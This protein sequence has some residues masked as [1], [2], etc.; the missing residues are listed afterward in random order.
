MARNTNT[1]ARAVA[2][3]V[4]ANTV[5][6]VKAPKAAPVIPQM[7]K[8]DDFPAGT[9]NTAVAAVVGPIADQLAEGVQGKFPF[10]DEDTAEKLGLQI[11]SALAQRHGLRLRK[12]YKD[13][14]LFVKA[15]GPI[16]HRSKD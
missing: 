13:G 5:S 12:L 7:E 4:Q 2:S 3:K 6:P 8:V 15:D 1:A 11:R 9:R 16:R 10:D 14:F